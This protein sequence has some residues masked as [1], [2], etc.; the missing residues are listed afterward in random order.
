MRHMPLVA[1]RST[2]KKDMRDMFFNFIFFKQ[3]LTYSAS[4]ACED[5]RELRWNR[6]LSCLLASASSVCS[7]IVTTYCVERMLTKCWT[8]ELVNPSIL[9]T[10]MKHSSLQG[11]GLR[12]VLVA[13]S[14]HTCQRRQSSGRSSTAV[15][16]IMNTADAA[17]ASGTR[18]TKRKRVIS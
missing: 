10:H 13:A 15:N 12:I 16:V 2:E 9:N 7:P 17:I 4:I 11:C 6:M 14:L 18:N 8:L 3:K 1:H 5:M